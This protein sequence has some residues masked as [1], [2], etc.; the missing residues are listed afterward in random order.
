[1][2]KHKKMINCAQSYDAFYLID[3]ETFKA[4][5]QKPSRTLLLHLH[6]KLFKFYF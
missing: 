5:S 6:F 3:S 4:E 2:K 1:M